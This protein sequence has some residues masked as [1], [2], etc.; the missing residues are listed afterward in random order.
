M[1]YGLMVG[2]FWGIAAGLG[3]IAV[4]SWLWRQWG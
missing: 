1:E 2:C 4:V 3:A